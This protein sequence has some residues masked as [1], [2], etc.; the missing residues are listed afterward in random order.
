LN[1]DQL[2]VATITWARNQDEEQLMGGAMGRLAQEELPT[3]ITDGGSV[4]PFMDYLHS[5][6]HFRVLERD[7]PGVLAQ[8]RRSLNAAYETGHPFI[9]YTESDKE[10]FFQNQLRDFIAQ[11]PSDKE[12]GVVLAA[13]SPASFATYP[14]SQQYAETVSNHLCTESFGIET[15]Y[16]YGPCIL[17]RDL[18]PYLELVQSDIGW[19]WRPFICGIAQRLGYSIVPLITDLPCPPGQREDSQTE[20]LHRLRQLSQNIQG[21]VL[22]LSLPDDQ[23]NAAPSTP[24]TNAGAA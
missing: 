9:L 16:F 20:R 19:G 14:P 17:H 7:K 5:F 21:L 11:A 8:T 6:P 23:L 10:W 4:Q 12:V 22:A 15:D 24:P 2:T 3:F 1:K 13:R 18:V